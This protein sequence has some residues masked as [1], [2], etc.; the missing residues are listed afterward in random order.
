MNIDFLKELTN[1]DGIAS[2]EKEVRKAILT[3][4]D[5]LHYEKRTDG[6]GSLIFTKKLGSWFVALAARG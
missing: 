1:A 6:L 5:G 3:E 4:L 2:N